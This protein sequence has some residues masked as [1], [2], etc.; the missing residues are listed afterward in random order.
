MVFHRRGCFSSYKV[1]SSNRGGVFECCM[2]AVC[3]LA[4]CVAW[5][6]L[7][8]CLRIFH[9]AKL[10]K[11][12]LCWEGWGGGRQHL[13]LSSVLQPAL[14]FQDSG[15]ADP[16]RRTAQCS[17]YTAGGTS[18]QDPQWT[19]Q[20]RGPD[21]SASPCQPRTQAHGASEG[22]AGR[23]LKTQSGE[24]GNTWLDPCRAAVPGE[25]TENIKTVNGGQFMKV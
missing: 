13:T 18:G 14:G 11:V 2:G 4:I 8:R 20:H 17:A 23:T 1:F 6:F 7:L 5:M 3:G 16:T 12:G 25:K 21:Q 9:T 22:G 19:G 15:R 10:R 24:L